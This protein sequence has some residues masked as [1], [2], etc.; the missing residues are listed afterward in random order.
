MSSGN[1]SSER[2]SKKEVF[3]IFSQYGK[4]AQI[5]LKQAYGFVQYHAVTEGQAATDAL[6]GTE[7]SG[8]KIRE[9]SVLYTYLSI[10]N[11]AQTSSSL[12]LKRRAMMATRNVAVVA[13]VA[14]VAIVA[15]VEAAVVTTRM[16]AVI[17]AVSTI[18]VVMVIVLGR[19]HLTEIV[20]P[21]KAPMVR[22]IVAIGNHPPTL[23]VGDRDRRHQVELVVTGAGVPVRTAERLLRKWISRFPGDMAQMCQMSNFSFCKT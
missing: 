12:V 14:T 9:S 1:L 6:Q 17:A 8:R 15:I 18:V 7:I 23:V 11:V 16:S 19:L 5:S 21:V 3:D 20:T 2:V 10:T 13:T 22:A 4:L